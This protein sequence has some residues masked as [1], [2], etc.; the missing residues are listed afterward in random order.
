METQINSRIITYPS[1]VDKSTNVTVTV[2]DPSVDDVENLGYFLQTSQKNY[3][4]YMYNSEHDDFQYLNEIVARSDYT[5]R[6]I[7]SSVEMTN[8]SLVN[9]GLGSDIADPLNYFK[10]LDKI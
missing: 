1:T 7:T 10:E 8:V 9:Y 5:L 4:V 6:N 3:D 2:V